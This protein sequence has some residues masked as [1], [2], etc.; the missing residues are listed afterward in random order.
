MQ[1]AVPE[2][3]YGPAQRNFNSDLAASN[4]DLNNWRCKSGPELHVKAAEGSIDLSYVLS[5]G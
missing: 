5:A 3:R 2:L 1:L 4:F